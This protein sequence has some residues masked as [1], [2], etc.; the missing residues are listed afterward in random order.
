[1]LAFVVRGQNYAASYVLSQG[2]LK[3]PT[4]DDFDRE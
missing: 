4:V 1:M 3:D 2:L